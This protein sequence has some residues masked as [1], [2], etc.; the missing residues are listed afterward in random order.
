[1]EDNELTTRLVRLETLL[2]WQSV[3]LQ[4]I[5]AALT[6]YGAACRDTHAAVETRLQAA[7]AQHAEVRSQVSLLQWL[8]LVAA[9]ALGGIVAFWNHLAGK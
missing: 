2:E 8:G 6:T 4:D 1:M 3:M 7:E 9:T 5:K